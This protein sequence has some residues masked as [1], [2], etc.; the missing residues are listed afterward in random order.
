M[1]YRFGDYT[2]DTSRWEL[3]RAGRLIKL[4][5]KVFD[6]LHHLIAHRDRVIT[7]QE[8]LDHLWPRQF[9]SDTTLNSCI[10][11]ARQAVGDTGQAQ[12]FIQ[13]LHGRGYRFVGAVE[14]GS[15][16]PPV[17]ARRASGSSDESLEGTATSRHGSP[18]VSGPE[19]LT[20]TVEH[21][22]VLWEPAQ[23]RL[24]SGGTSPDALEGERKAV[25]ILCCALVDARGHAAHLD[26]EAMYRLMQGFFALV[27][28]VVLRYGGTLTQR[29]SDGVMA[30]FGA[31][32]AHEDHA[33]R[34]VLAA[35]EL[36]RLAREDPSLRAPFA[37]TS[38]ST[39]M[40]LHSGMVIVGPVGRDVHTLYAALDE[41][42]E[43]AGR[44]QR[45]AG[46]DT[47]LMSE[48]TRR[49]VQEEVKVEAYEALDRAEL[50]RSLSVYKACEVMIRRS[51][52]PGRGGRLLSPFVGRARELASLRALLA[53]V[54]AGQ[55]QVVGIV[56]EPGLGKSRLLYEFAQTLRGTPMD[57]LEGHCLPYDQ[58]TPYGPVLGI[59]R[60]LCGM[61]DGDDPEVLT[62]KLRR[63]LH[64]AGLTPDADAPYL[65]TLLGLPEGAAPLA[66]VSPEVRKA[67]TSTVLRHL[68]LH[69]DAGRVR[70]IA[71]ENVHWSDPTS[72]E[73][74]ARLADSLWGA[75]LLL[76]TTYRPGYRPPWLDK[77][78]ATQ[79]ALSRLRPWASR[80][81]LQAVLPAAPDEGS[82]EQTII[83]MAAGNPFFLEELAWALREGG[84]T[85][86]TG[87]I[88]DTV[89]A[90]LAARIDRLQPT[91]KRLLQIA[92][93][94]G[95][96][97]PLGLLQVIAD[98]P[99]DTLQRA[100]ARLQASEFLFET[101]RAPDL[102][103][104]FKHALT[105]EVA[106]N[107]LLQERRRTLHARIA[108]ALEGLYAGRLS[109]QVER[110]AHHAWQGELWEKTVTYLRQAGAKA[111]ESSANREAVAHFER[112]LIA[113]E[114]LP[115]SRAMREQA[116]D[117]RCDMRLALMPLNEQGRRLALL[118][119]AE[120]L[121]Q[122]LDDQPRLG[123]VSIMIA[124]CLRAMGEFE[125]AL[126]A[127]HQVLDRATTLRDV[128]L[129]AVAYFV[130]GEVYY[131]LG[132]YRRAVDMLRRNVEALDR[133]GPQERF[134]RLSLG[135]GLQTVAS[136][137]WLLQ[138]LAGLGAFAEARVIAAETLRLA[139]SDGHPYTLALAYARVSFLY[140]G[141]GEVHR[142]IPA[143][144]RALELCRV[145][146][147]Q[148][149]RTGIYCGLGYALALSGRS[150]D[151]LTL[152]ERT[153]GQA[154]SPSLLGSAALQAW[155]SEVSLL[156]GDVA[157][158]RT[159]AVQALALARARQERG[160]EAWTLRLLGDIAMHR[161]CP[162]VESAE[163]YYLR[164]L[165]L[166]DELGMRPLVAHCRL[167]LGTL[168][169]RAGCRGPTRAELCAAIALYHAMDMTLWLPQAEATLA[170]VEDH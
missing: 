90:V 100:L 10:R 44:L 103:Y 77:S 135:P 169:A 76:V 72:E 65:L 54:E 35:L 87:T 7:R 25:T 68:S 158:A 91:D 94:I 43:V 159:L 161:D 86:S 141:Q 56:G 139:E 85:Q 101:R 29:H 55:G 73:Y 165:D 152:L 28:R 148:Q 48:T 80:A 81:V 156:A 88:P 92:A 167:G 45:L 79:L 118:R 128:N 30:L 13:T 138:A 123:S 129:Q 26:A 50:P 20:D 62:T 155:V 18:A 37:G 137:C 119:E 34:A 144:E 105:H 46:P 40:G 27:Q 71:V 63:R 125:H 58:T 120:A 15:E 1:R 107:S 151:A 51:G 113:L 124:H 132:D 69:G 116:I 57:Y 74:L 117:V 102:A 168:Y 108:D 84:L 140:L 23:A 98:L 32:V 52:V 170:E 166:A 67:R 121:A 112:V 110:L 145:G 21:S 60:Q 162:G 16:S 5:P 6:V 147:I 17:G 115:R 14:E 36:Q 131:A 143:L 133:A 154:P 3:R 96:E 19:G 53:Q 160:N 70:V 146:D 38:L 41:T 22:P 82:W 31:P 24:G 130:L 9:I 157:A 2:F 126:A 142:A 8:L 127:G 163:H 149:Y 111:I 66:G 150:R 47:I 104:T 95:H 153:V 42:M 49:W 64:E 122:A 12:R 99:E 114:H 11:E 89:H 75:K 33:R 59:L 97:V 4:R 83:D 109:E 164:A 78:Y 93:V 61:T 39:S 106:Y 136:R 134:G